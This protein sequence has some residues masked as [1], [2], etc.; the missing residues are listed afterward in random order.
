MIGLPVVIRF[1]PERI[2][3]RNWSGRSSG[4]LTKDRKAGPDKIV[5]R[6]MRGQLRTGNLLT[7]QL[8]IA[9][10][11][12][13]DAPKAKINWNAALPEFPTVRSS[14]EELKSSVTR[15]VKKLDKVDYEGIS[16]DLKETMK[17]T[18]KMMNGLDASIADLTPE[19]KVVIV[20]ARRALV[21]ADRAI[22]PDSPLLQDTRAMM[23]EVSR[24]AQAFRVLADYL[25]RHPEALISGK[26]ADDQKDGGRQE[27]SK[28]GEKK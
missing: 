15:I 11:Y 21:A 4:R 23:M 1:Y 13:P 7:G 6:G 17:S 9:L 20:E 10:D 22:A 18:T 8:F 26:K 2:T 12:F 27:E 24:A 28:K 25:E 3:S 16:A 19:T 5:G 14:L